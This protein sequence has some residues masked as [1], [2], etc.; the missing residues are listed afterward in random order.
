MDDPWKVL[1]IEPT[2]TLEEARHAYKMRSQLFHPD[3]HQGASPEVLKLANQEFRDLTEAWQSVR[4]SLGPQESPSASS[5]TNQSN[6]RHVS[7]TDAATLAVRCATCGTAFR[8]LKNSTKF[9]CPRCHDIFHIARCPNCGRPSIV[10]HWIRRWVCGGCAQSVD[11]TWRLPNV[12]I[13]CD[14]CKTE[15]LVSS[16]A[17]G[18]QCKR[19]RSLHF[20]RTCT[21]CG[22]SQFVRRK[23]G[24][25]STWKCKC[26][27]S[28][29]H[30][31]RVIA[32]ALSPD[33]RARTRDV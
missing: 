11:A 20:R 7:T 27:T 5:K 26:G 6:E 10:R 24:P 23:S 18:F 1:G 31:K 33:G 22:R 30:E 2:A 25:I 9:D 21:R 4:R 8:V 17:Q 19:C 16:N 12:R 13:K 14:K 28:N 29:P 32:S 15:T 3:R